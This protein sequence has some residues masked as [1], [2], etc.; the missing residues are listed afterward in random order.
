MQGVLCVV[1]MIK[2]NPKEILGVLEHL[3]REYPDKMTAGEL[4]D[5]YL[6]KVVRNE[7]DLGLDD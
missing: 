3:V 2:Y 6:Q 5:I 1:K 7:M 4:R